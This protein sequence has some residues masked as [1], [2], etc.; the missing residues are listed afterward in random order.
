ML[1]LQEVWNFRVLFYKEAERSAK[2]ANFVLSPRVGYPRNEQ[3]PRGGLVTSRR[4]TSSTSTP[5]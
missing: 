1:I 3:K 2:L 5:T 4:L